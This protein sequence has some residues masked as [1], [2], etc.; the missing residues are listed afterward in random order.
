MT[1]SLKVRAHA[2]VNLGLQILGRRP[3]GFHEVISVMQAIS[4]H[5]LITFN[6]ADG[7]E[8]ESGVEGLDV[9]E[10]LIWRAANAL[11]E[12]AGVR[13][14]AAV[15]VEKNIPARAGLGG[16]SSDGAATL[17]ALNELWGC[18]MAPE[19]LA[20]IAATLG[21]DMGFF[22][23]GGTALAQ[24]RGEVVTPI[25]PAPQ[26]W[27][28]LAMPERSLSTPAVYAE[29]RPSEHSDGAATRALA[30][31]IERGELPYS[32]MRNDLA[33]PA[34]RLCPEISALLES[35]A[36]QGSQTA[37]VSGS[38]SACFGLFAERGAALDCERALGE[39]SAWTRICQ[40]EGAW[41]PGAP[42]DRIP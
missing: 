26:R 22:L 8:V 20:A 38:G 25:P 35:F 16:G 11:R 24:G 30:D 33:G 3:D 6:E 34:R 19:K 4:L 5:D 28:L 18:G 41:G 37:M 14:G 39:C 23:A 9:R 15:K 42:W 29:L 7:L 2:K 27:V 40:F 17:L 21:S 32:H 12:A 10:D 31:G 13:R 36:A 1:A